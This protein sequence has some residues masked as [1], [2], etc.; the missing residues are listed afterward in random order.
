MGHGFDDQGAKSDGHG[1]LRDWW[2]PDDVARFK[3]LT[4]KLASQYSGFEALPGLNVNGRFTLG[5]NIGDNGGMQVAYAAYRISLKGA[6]A[7]V[8]D[9]FTGDQRFF[10]GWAQVWRGLIRDEALRVQVASDP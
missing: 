10:L 2:G 7:P 3:V 4:D 8:L 1:V 9:G 6:E 5:E